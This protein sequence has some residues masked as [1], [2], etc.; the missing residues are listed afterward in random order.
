MIGRLAKMS[1]IASE[2]TDLVLDSNGD[3]AVRP[4][5]IYFLRNSRRYLSCREKR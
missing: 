2:L 3:F 5:E 1:F 4:R